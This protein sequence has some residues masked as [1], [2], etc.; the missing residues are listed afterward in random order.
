MLNLECHIPLCHLRL[1]TWHWFLDNVDDSNRRCTSLCWIISRFI[2]D[3]QLC[4]H[5]K[6]NQL[7]FVM[8][9]LSVFYR[10]EFFLFCRRIGSKQ[11]SQSKRV[12]IL[13]NAKSLNNDLTDSS[14]FASICVWR[15]VA[16]SIFRVFLND[17]VWN[18]YAFI[19]CRSWM[20]TRSVLELWTILEANLLR[21]DTSILMKS[22][23]PLMVST[24]SKS[25]LI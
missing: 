4:F 7:N 3:Y 20:R 19:P 9:S 1:K 24:Q 5:H 10:N 12:W 6:L 23:T 25:S 16:F 11:L 8:Y 14:R 22:K 21:K 2:L 17:W 13:K 18:E 15:W